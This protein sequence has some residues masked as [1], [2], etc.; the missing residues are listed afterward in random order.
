MHDYVLSSFIS[1]MQAY[2][3]YIYFYNASNYGLLAH[4]EN[5][6]LKEIYKDR[7]FEIA[8]NTSSN[9][10]LF[11]IRRTNSVLLF[12][13]ENGSLSEIKLSVN[14]VYTIK[15]ILCDNDSCFIVFCSDD[16]PDF[17][18]LIEKE[19]IADYTFPCM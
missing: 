18:Y 2:E 14:N 8:A 4:V 16:S 10:P 3:D 13:V 15:T 6:S 5:D 7:D 11:Y 9:Q 17:A 12:D 19:K 1:D